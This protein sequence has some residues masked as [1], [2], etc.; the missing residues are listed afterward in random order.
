[1]W[2]AIKGEKDFI[3]GLVFVFIGVIAVIAASGE[4]IGRAASMGPGY[5]PALVGIIL[6]LLGGS[7][8]IIGFRSAQR[9]PIDFDGWRP[10]IAIL[11]STIAFAMLLE[12]AG[13]VV[14]ILVCLVIA[15]WDLLRKHPVQFALLYLGLTLFCV[16][17]FIYGFGMTIPVFWWE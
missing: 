3:A 5:F 10:F 7:S 2:K 13:L 9:D 16:G 8:A 1:M 14:T 6:I 12:R 17:S 15:C 4:D 11:A